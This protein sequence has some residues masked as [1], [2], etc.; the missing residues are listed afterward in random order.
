MMKS[1]TNEEEMQLLVKK[2]MNSLYGEQRRNDN[3]EKYAHKT[4]Y[5]MSTEFE[6]RVKDYWE[7]SYANYFVK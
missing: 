2:L 1:L 7:W 4:E 3:K 6:E 5:W